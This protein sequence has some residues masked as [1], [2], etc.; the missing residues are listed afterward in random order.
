MND[1]AD[2]SFRLFDELILVV[3]E[4]PRNGQYSV[5]GILLVSCGHP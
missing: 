5:N 3:E 2:P 4:K 1:W